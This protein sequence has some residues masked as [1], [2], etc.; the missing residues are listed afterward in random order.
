[1]DLYAPLASRIGMEKVK[2]E[3]EELA[4]AELNP[5]GRASVLARQG[6]CAS[7]ASG[8]CRRSNPS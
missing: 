7:A 8:W 4:F 6:Y 5:D 1:M 3:L 2:R